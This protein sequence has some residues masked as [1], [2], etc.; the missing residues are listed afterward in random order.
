MHAETTPQ[1][2]QTFA[3]YL[4]ES[5]GEGYPEPQAEGAAETEGVAESEGQALEE[6]SP[7]VEAL[8]LEGPVPPGE[9][10]P[11]EEALERARL[12]AE[13]EQAGVE[14]GGLIPDQLVDLEPPLGAVPKLRIVFLGMNGRFST[15]A[16]QLLATSHQIVGIVCSKLRAV[17]KGLVARWV[18]AG[19]G[20]G[21]LERFAE[22][23]RCP[24]FYAEREY[25]YQLLRFIKH[26]KPDLICI[27][28]FSIILPPDIYELAPQGAINLHLAPLPQYR[29]PNP[30]LWLFYDGCQESEYVVHQVDSGEDTGPI[31]GRQS[32]NIPPNITGSELADC[33][34]P[35][36]ACL[37]LRVV[38]EIALGESE[39]QPQKVEGPLRRARYVKPGEALIDWEEW[40]C[41]RVGAFLR[42][43]SLWYEPFPIFPC[44]VRLY[45][46]GQVG[47]SYGKPGTNHW[48]L[49]KGWISCKDGIVPY[50]VAIL[51][52]EF[53]RL[54]IPILILLIIGFIL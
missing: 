15:Q 20:E 35:G 16:L 50:K 7:Q 1:E 13:L 24:Y 38:E 29:G 19:K 10:A 23:Y 41:Q 26:L 12:Q 25:N 51:R 33:V 52:Y 4:S 47:P 2:A 17:K 43:A 53:W 21:N 9:D 31:L 22:Y 44:L 8:T 32:F 28:N 48:R 11:L 36:A 27:S 39:P 49:W 46:P 45:Q 54:L 34:L 6:A 3:Q 30:W 14:E 5:L 40:G 18:S 42:G 37:M